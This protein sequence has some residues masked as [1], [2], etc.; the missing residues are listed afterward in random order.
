MSHFEDYMNSITP[1]YETD[2]PRSRQ[3]ACRRAVLR[4]IRQAKTPRV[5][6]SLKIALL[7]AAAALTVSLIGP[8]SALAQKPGWRETYRF[9]PVW[10]EDEIEQHEAAVSPLLHTEPQRCS[11]EGFTLT[12]TGYASDGRAGTVFLE[13]TAPENFDWKYPYLEVTGTQQNLQTGQTAPASLSYLTGLTRTRR[14]NVLRAE[15]ALA[16]SEF[17]MEDRAEPPVCSVVLDHICLRD[18]YTDFSDGGTYLKGSSNPHSVTFDGAFT[19]ETGPTGVCT[20]RED[21]LLGHIR[22]TPFSVSCSSFD[23]PDTAL[24]YAQQLQMGL[25]PVLKLKNGETFS[26]DSCFCFLP[27]ASVH[28]GLPEETARWSG[29]M[30]MI[31]RHP[32]SLDEIAGLSFDGIN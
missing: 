21:P 16:L 12:M 15:C 20:E 31:F 23:D 1:E 24:R 8:L 10:T 22:I 4:E 30:L 7:A 26:K 32:V 29:G 14:A 6:R 18:E 9:A 13:L 19:L 28:D 25:T 17:C 3:R 2:Y 27:W 5:R 11:A